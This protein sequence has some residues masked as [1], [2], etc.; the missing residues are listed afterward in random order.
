MNPDLLWVLVAFLIGGLFNWY[1]GWQKS[2]E[3]FSLRKFIS[4]MV[5]LLAS[6]GATL[7]LYS[8]SI[9]ISIQDL[10]AVFGLGFAVDTIVKSGAMVI[11][12]KISP[13]AAPAAAAAPPA[14]PPGENTTD[15]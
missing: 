9:N 3:S 13:A 1:L 2:G 15:H 5:I 4:S 7:V 6:S 14:P 8:Q 10:I 11:T 12:N